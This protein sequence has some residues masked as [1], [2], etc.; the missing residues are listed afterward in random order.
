MSC[1]IERLLTSNNSVILRV[2]GHIQGDHVNTLSELLGQEQQQVTLDLADV[3]LVD[4]HAVKL[5]AA[6][7]SNGVELRNCPGYVRE[8]VSRLRRSA[9]AGF[10]TRGEEN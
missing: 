8:W 7:E 10:G 5:L 2:S 6:S 9:D 4:R 3:N 1:K